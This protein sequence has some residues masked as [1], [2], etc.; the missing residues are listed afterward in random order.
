MACSI[1]SVVDGSDVPSDLTNLVVSAKM[2]VGEGVVLMDGEVWRGG[3]VVEA[4]LG[5]PAG[6]GVLVV[7]GNVS[8]GMAFVVPVSAEAAV[9][10][11]VVLSVATASEAP[12]NAVE[13]VVGATV[14]G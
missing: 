14:G 12:S 8:T 4:V 10:E 2:V 13:V 3:E 6:V 5:K 9:L 1:V 11:T 7:D